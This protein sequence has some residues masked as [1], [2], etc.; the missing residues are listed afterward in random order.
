MCT[1][2]G[3]L[4]AQCSARGEVEESFPEMAKTEEVTTVPQE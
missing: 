1:Y 2:P 4:G 3:D